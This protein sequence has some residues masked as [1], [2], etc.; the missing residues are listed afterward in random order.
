LLRRYP[1]LEYY[2][3]LPYLLYPFLLNLIFNSIFV[4]NPDR[5][6]EILGRF[7]SYFEM[8]GIF[9][10][11]YI[12]AGLLSLLV[13]YRQANQLS[14][15]KMRIVVAGSIAGFLPLLIFLGLDLLFDVN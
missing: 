10:L 11:F 4:I 7:R 6:F 13:N 8:S 9:T 15:R 5:A 2:F 3:Y 14:R 12:I 1:K